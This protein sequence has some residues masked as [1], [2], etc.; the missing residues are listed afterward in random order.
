MKFWVNKNVLII[1]GGGLAVLVLA[2]CLFFWLQGPSLPEEGGNE[3]GKSTVTQ[4]L[5]PE[6]SVSAQDTLQ[7][8]TNNL[9]GQ[10]LH[11]A[12]QYLKEGENM[13]ACDYLKDIPP[14]SA[15]RVEAVDLAKQIEGCILN[16]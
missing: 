5:T 6:T 4:K 2:I 13:D 16:E 14:S 10:Y 15:Y 12:K 3:A 9:Y 11:M 7:P 8:Q 1:G